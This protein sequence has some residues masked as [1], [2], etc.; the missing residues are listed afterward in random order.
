MDL[1]D[2]P[3]AMTII[4]LIFALVLGVEQAG[5]LPRRRVLET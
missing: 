3:Q 1:F 4:P 2:Y 5:S